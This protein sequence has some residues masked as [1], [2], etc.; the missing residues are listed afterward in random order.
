MELTQTELKEQR[1]QKLFEDCQKQVIS[2]I[3]GPFGLS[4][5]MF[6][7]KTG[8]NVT[9]QH[10]AEKDIFAKESEEFDREKD[11]DY[12]AAKSKKKQDAVKDGSMNSQ[13]FV[14][15]YTGEKE[16]SRR[17][18]SEG[19]DVAN[20]EL[21]HLIPVKDIHRQG[22]W[23]KDKKGRKELSSEMDNLHYTTHK[24]NRSKSDKAPEDALSEEN[25]FDKERIKPLIEKAQN[26][27]DEKLPT[28]S[29]RL[30]YHGKELLS[31]GSSQAIQMG[32]RQALGVLLTELVNALFNEM[33]LLIQ[34]GVEVGKTLFEDISQR[35][36]RVVERL[37]KKAPEALSQM[38]QG[39]I[40]GFMS[41]LITY[42]INTFLTTA[43]R[44]VTV[45]REGLLG[46][47]KAFKM[48]FF[49]PEGMS[50]EKALQEGLKIL[51]AVI[52]TSLGILLEETV[53]NFLK[54]FPFADIVAP[55]LV[56][57]ITGLLLA[58][59]SY[60]IDSLFDRL[61][62][63]NDERLM[64]ELMADATRRD[65][66]ANE[67]ANLTAGALESIESYAESIK[68]YQNIGAVFGEAGRAG[69][70]TLNSLKTINSETHEQVIRSNE[71]KDRINASHIEVENFLKTI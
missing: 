20:F 52:V 24:T 22:G 53:A 66:F 13:E 37:A 3:M 30:Q 63:L 29:E 12:S 7:D 65:E 44:I 46:L 61:L 64:D 8:G 48:I 36:G 4:Q 21:D 17:K 41:N 15:Q 19:K 32:A 34:Q 14:D 56:G 5:A 62:R 45:I 28:A 35:L 1:L 54:A 58:F 42:L 16:P 18:D 31:T 51:T 6:E 40:S 47:Y 50:R 33:K 59:L 39:G 60:Q 69:V 27:I 26:A 23:M 71:A 68:T 2:Q 11:Y 10:N 70:A 25:G 9:T 43:K 67:L 38:F 55:V 49:P 57:I